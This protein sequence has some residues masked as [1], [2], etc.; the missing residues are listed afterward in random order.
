MKKLHLACLTCLCGCI[1]FGFTTGLASALPPFK[2]E[3]QKVYVDGGSD[4][5]KTSFK[6]SKIGGCQTCHVKGEKK[7]V[8]NPY[9]KEL[10]DRIEGN[11]KQRLKD[12]SANGGVDAKQAEQQKL[13]AELK[14]AFLEVEPLPSPSG[15]GTYGER[16]EAGQLPYVP[17]Q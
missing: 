5:L 7:S 8:N 15:G 17:E 9:G 3:F 13:I 4:D 10:A 11:A 2:K 1:A 12:A 14:A 6:N 16:I